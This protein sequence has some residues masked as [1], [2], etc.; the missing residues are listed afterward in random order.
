MLG[1][2]AGAEQKGN[3]V[4]RVYLLAFASRRDFPLAG[5]DRLDGR[6]QARKDRRIGDGN[7]VR[8]EDDIH[9]RLQGGDALDGSDVSIEIGLGSIKPDGRGIVGVAGEE[10]SVR[11]VE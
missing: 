1:R 8:P 11:A 5:T 10:Q 7:I 2:S 3:S 4:K 6:Y 9:L